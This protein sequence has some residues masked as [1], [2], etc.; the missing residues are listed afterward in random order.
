MYSDARSRLVLG[1]TATNPNPIPIPG[2]S[3]GR[4]VRDSSDSDEL[5]QECDL[6]LEEWIRRERRN[7]EKTTPLFGVGKALKMRQNEGICSIDRA[8]YWSRSSGSREPRVC[9]T[10]NRMRTR[11]PA[12]AGGIVEEHVLQDSFW[13]VFFTIPDCRRVL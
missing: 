12:V 5:H 7:E 3:Y 10:L 2:Y 4:T 6:I 1:S 9:D 11:N 8:A 13:V